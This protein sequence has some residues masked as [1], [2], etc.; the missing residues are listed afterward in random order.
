MTVQGPGWV[1]GLWGRGISLPRSLLSAHL[2]LPLSAWPQFDHNVSAGIAPGPLVLPGFI[3]HASLGD[4]NS[5][6]C[7]LSFE[8]VGKKSSRKILLQK[9]RNK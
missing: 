2:L 9:W 8:L 7:L 4:V 6:I 1:L 5:D 3:N